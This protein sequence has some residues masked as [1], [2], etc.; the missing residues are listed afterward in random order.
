MLLIND[1]II[2][3]TFGQV[4]TIMFLF[5]KSCKETIIS[6]MKLFYDFSSIQKY[7]IINYLAINLD[8]T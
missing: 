7:K 1:S 6:R 5:I 2:F 4:R 8:N 3:S